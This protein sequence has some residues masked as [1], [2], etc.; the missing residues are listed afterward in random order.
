MHKHQ[1]HIS[2]GYTPCGTYVKQVR[3][4]PDL[5][6]S[7]KGLLHFKLEWPYLSQENVE[8]NK[9]KYE[10]QAAEKQVQQAEARSRRWAICNTLR[11]RA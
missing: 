6:G 11:N 1:L 5:G 8:K 4:W 9:P 10:A 7:Q 3:I 2:H